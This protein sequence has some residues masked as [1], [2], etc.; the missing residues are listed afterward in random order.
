MPRNNNGVY[1]LPTGNP[2]ISGT[3][4]EAEWAN[5]TMEDIA[6]AL[7]NSVPRNGSAPMTGPLI[8]ASTSPT[9]PTEA[10]SKGYV[11]KFLAYSTGMPVGAVAPYAGNQVPSGWL[12]CNGAA[13]SRTAYADLFAA[14]GTVFGA[15]DGAL[16]FNLPDLRNEFI[17]GTGPAR[18]LGTKQAAAIAAHNHEIID[19][20]HTHVTVASVASHFHSISLATTYAGGATGTVGIGSKH[21]TITTGGLDGTATGVF[22]VST[23]ATDLP[24]GTGDFGGGFR[25]LNMDVPAHS[26]QVLGVTQSEKPGAEVTVDSA[27]TGVTTGQT[28]SV[29]TVPQN[30]A[31]NYYI[32]AVNDSTAADPGA[33]GQRFLGFFDAS[34]GQLP[35]QV[36]PT[37]TY[38]AGDFYQI[39]VPG[40][41]TVYDPATGVQSQMTVTVGSNITWV[42]PDSTQASGWYYTSHST[43]TAAAS[44][45]FSPSG[46]IGATNVQAAIQEL[47]AEKA[48]RGSAT[49]LGT[50]FQPAVGITATNVQLAIEQAATMG[51]PTTI[52]SAVTF[53]PTGNISATNVQSAIAELDTEKVSLSTANIPNGYAKLDAG[54]LVPAANLPVIASGVSSVNSR[55][56]AV[57]LSAVDVGLAN[58][59]NTSDVNKPI[60]TATQ[61]ALNDKA[62]VS[63]STAVGTSVT[64]VG[65]ISATT[66]QAAI[67]E[68]DAEKVAVDTAN[69]PNGY[70]KLDAAG[71]VPTANLPTSSRQ[72]F[73]V[74]SE[75]EMLALS[76]A[77]VGDTAVRTDISKTFILQTAGAAVLAHWVE[78]LTPTSAVTS[79]AGRTGDVVLSSTDVGLANVNN[80]SDLNKPISTATQTA[81]DAKA[82]V[83]ASTAIGTS[84]APYGGVSATD[85]QF[86]IQELDNE[87]VSVNTA[88]IPNGY[89]KL[90]AG[91]KVPAANLPASA[92][93]VSSVNTRTGAVTL[94]AADVGLSNVNNTSDANKPISTATQTALNAKAPSSA[95][96]ASGTSFTPVSTIQATD[97]QAAIAEMLTD[98]AAGTGSQ[99]VGYKNASPNSSLR[100]VF[101]K[102]GDTLSVKDFGAVGDGLANDTLAINN[103]IAAANAGKKA[104]Y[105]PPGI[106]QYS[107]GGSLTAGVTILGDGPYSSIIKALTAAPT[108][109]FSCDGVGSGIDGIGFVPGPTQT[110]GTWVKLVSPFSTIQNFRFD[111]DFNAILMLGVAARIRHGVFGAGAVN[112]IRI[113]VAGGDTSQLIDDIIMLQT[114]PP[115]VAAA[116]IRVRDSAALMITNTSV[117]NQNVG[118]LIDPVSQL[119]SVFSMYVNNCFFDNCTKALV[120]S[121]SNMAAV[122]RSRFANSWFSSST[123]DGVF[124]GGSGQA[125]LHFES[126]DIILNG[127]AGISL[128]ENCTDITVN[129][130]SLCSNTHGIYLN[131]DV[132]G[133]SV[134]NAC[135]GQ[136]A[137][138]LPGNSQWGVVI[139]EGSE[140]TMVTNNIMRNNGLGAIANASEHAETVIFNNLGSSIQIPPT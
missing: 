112:S 89:A 13:V 27:T 128:W 62:P 123:D 33:T 84:F 22:T 81:L 96:L 55:A 14:I 66:V 129:G 70:A 82:P 48:P 50:S 140:W 57:T 87:K 28:G 23:T 92:S 76:A 94:S 71:L 29:E 125:G 73:V 78:M 58:V 2:V 9:S 131:T 138:N 15:G 79:V 36:F 44:V 122:Q 114:D 119:T 137:G 42:A 85:V 90:D 69:L 67:Q 26:H 64:P 32:K 130:G 54:G 12:Q 98:T 83:N 51:S 60:S 134:T 43:S 116:G 132:I 127:G 30:V 68:L 65:G 74:A 88:N 110:G 39:G 24:I 6:E 136:G 45:S 104:L 1:E 95:S 102:L 59:N 34:S 3:L 115:N 10:V 118:L 56:G 93:G 80:T 18:P 17:R 105:F 126:C 16:T 52:A 107:G 41:L 103:G 109:L 101:A 7:T 35:Q 106:Y 37:F 63:A 111:G 21:P 38:L 25:T 124:I 91:G 113:D 135:I 99:T 77:A 11:D 8:L 97:V 61:A 40:T 120:I 19:T 20:G 31:L 47:D 108:Y 100:T 139:S 46:D 117:I 5:D 121:P 86:A 133:L 72:T 75:A 49:A 53:T 4:I